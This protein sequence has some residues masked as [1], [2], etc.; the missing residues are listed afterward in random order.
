MASKIIEKMDENFFFFSNENNSELWNLFPEL[1]NW[2]FFSILCTF[3]AEFSKATYRETLTDYVS[4]IPCQLSALASDL[5][6]SK[7][8]SIKITPIQATENWEM[9][10]GDVPSCSIVFDAENILKISWI[11]NKNGEKQTRF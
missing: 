5:W 3:G 10:T 7:T 9:L 8:L 4:A 2:I 11:K 6:E 1:L